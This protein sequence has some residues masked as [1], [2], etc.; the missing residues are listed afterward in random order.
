VIRPDIALR[1]AQVLDM[2]GCGLPVCAMEY[3]CIRELVS[4]GDNG[5]LF[6]GPAQ[7]AEQLQALL[8][9]FPARPSKQLRHLQRV[10]AAADDVRWADTWAKAVLPV[11]RGALRER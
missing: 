7:L 1:K 11:V 10:V 9:A 8:A 3:D 4:D 6:S 5:L 2:F